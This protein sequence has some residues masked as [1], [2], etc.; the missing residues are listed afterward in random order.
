MVG[1][2]GHTWTAS[3]EDPPL[4]TSGVQRTV[5]TIPQISPHDRFPLQMNFRG[6]TEHV[7]NVPE[8]FSNGLKKSSFFPSDKQV[9][10]DFWTYHNRMGGFSALLNIFNRLLHQGLFLERFHT[11][12]SNK[13]KISYMEILLRI[14][15]LGNFLE[16]YY[17]EI[18]LPDN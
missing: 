2:T 11:H 17:Q 8:I 1:S 12:S 13:R 9:K 7:Y 14:A 10:N 16:V 4:R 6:L 18:V 5:L 3:S 15:I